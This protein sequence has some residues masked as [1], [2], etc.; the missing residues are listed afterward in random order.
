MST[1]VNPGVAARAIQLCRTQRVAVTGLWNSN[2]LQ[3]GYGLLEAIQQSFVAAG[4]KLFAAGPVTLSS[5]NQSTNA[6]NTNTAARANT[7]C[8]GWQ[9]VVT[10]ASANSLL[11][12]TNILAMHSF[13]SQRYTFGRG[14]DGASLQYPPLYRGLHFKNNAA[15]GYSGVASGISFSATASSP[16]HI[17][18]AAALRTDHWY[19]NATAAGG[20][21]RPVAIQ[22]AVPNVHVAN[23][24][25]AITVPAGTPTA[26]SRATWD[27]AAAARD[28]QLRIGPTAGTVSPDGRPTGEVFF[29][30]QVTWERDATAG[31]LVAPFESCGGWSTYDFANNLA[32]TDGSQC[33]DEAID[34]WI[35]V[36]VRPILDASQTP[37][38]LFFINEGSNEASETSASIVAAAA[39]GSVAAYTDNVGYIMSRWA[40]RWAA[41]GYAADRLIFVLC[42]DHPNL[43]SGEPARAAM[44]AGVE[45]LCAANPTNCIGLDS[46]G[47]W[48]TTAMKN[49]GLG[50]E[51]LYERASAS[52]AITG[53][54]TSFDGSPLVIT[55]TNTYTTAD[56]LWVTGTNCTPNINGTWA[57]SA[58]TST[59]VTV[60]PSG[61]DVTSGGTTGAIRTIDSLHLSSIGVNGATASG[62]RTY[63]AGM[64]GEWLLASA[65]TKTAMGLGLGIAI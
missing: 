31:V 22:G 39:G 9:R 58:R 5:T 51:T 29:G 62:Y 11:D 50:Q 16:Y 28:T 17:N 26:M 63:W 40:A 15:V 13:E 57:I 1:I 8:L 41:K 18:P 65:G 54:G 38:M 4:I 6:D 44:V 33:Y 42:P 61:F 27:V 32:R 30:F 24:G 12:A 56:V 21:F 59:T 19:S 25:S 35:D 52:Q 10:S 55:V 3:G 2:G 37:T 23:Y 43:S 20:T 34:H 60:V 36:V 7:S 45:S 53:I 46:L 48:T 14:N 64:F 49:V 47:R